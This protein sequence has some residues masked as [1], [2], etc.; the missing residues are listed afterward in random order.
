MWLLADNDFKRVDQVYKKHARGGNVHVMV[1]DFMARHPLHSNPVL[2]HPPQ[3][4]SLLP[5]TL[6][7][8]AGHLLSM[9]LDL[10]S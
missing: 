10:A 4:C 5:T 9:Y 7:S 8:E 3:N 2:A 6:V 1:I